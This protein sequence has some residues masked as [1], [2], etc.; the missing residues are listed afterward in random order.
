MVRTAPV[1]YISVTLNRPEAS[2]AEDFFPAPLAEGR[3]DGELQAAAAATGIAFAPQSLR[4]SSPL[5]RY[6]AG[7][8][9]SFGRIFSR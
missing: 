4:A 3:Q 7:G 2:D 6:S 8:P 5:G 9:P 1:K